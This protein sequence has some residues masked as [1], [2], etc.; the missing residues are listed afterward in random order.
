[1]DLTV[2]DAARSELFAMMLQG[3]VTLGLALVCLVLYLRYRKRYFAYWTLAWSLYAL[4][5][6]AIISFVLTSDR[7]W[8]YWHQ[9]VTGMTALALLWTALV[10]SR[11]LPW[12][13][14][15]LWLALFPVV[16]SYLAIY[17]LDNFLLAALPAVA[18]LSIATLWTGWVF[19][20]YHRQVESTGAASLALTL[21]LWGLHHLD[22]PFL[23][24]RGAWDPWGYYLD[25]LFILAMG[26]GILLLVVE[27]Q[28]RGI[29][30][31]SALSGD[32]HLAGSRDHVDGLTNLL[33]RPL[34]LAGV[35]GSAMYLLPDDELERGGRF[36]GGVGVCAEWPK[37]Q[38]GGVAARAIARAV[39]TREPQIEHGAGKANGGSTADMAH[40]SALPVIRGE[41]VW[42][43]LVMV[44]DLSDPFAV[45]D[46]RF[47]VTLGQ[48]VGAALESAELNRRLEARTGDLERLAARMV[49]QHEE[50]RKRLARELHDE[51]AQVFSAI[52]LHL[53][54][55]RE[56]ASQEQQNRLDRVM[57]LVDEGI[58]SVR[59]VARDLRPELL[60]DLGLVPALRAVVTD[61]EEQSGL[62]TQLNIRHTLPNLSDEA[63]LAL[64]RAL[65]EGLSNVARHADAKSVEVTLEAGD[66]RIRMVVCDDGSG[67]NGEDLDGLELDGHMGL[68]GMRERIS[69]LGGAVALRSNSTTGLSLQVELPLFEESTGE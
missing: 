50:E 40:V 31:L 64:F 29:G 53:D 10:F 25:I 44:G 61:F 2:T 38:P 15:Y 62:I 13:N 12:R 56:S 33:Q 1:M 23:R 4:R 36:I 24:A 27:E 58:R 39:E 51:T 45:L 41:E 30:M 63:E 67:W 14:R 28:H 34:K 46:N 54:V 48:Q 19:F 66:D 20:R 68:V 22:Y 32:L 8:L 17:R 9:V 60:D 26:T 11:Q 42:G 47:L 35:R 59:N 37:I 57:S 7:V 6:G 49:K 18:F 16:W 43:V 21:F 52:K 65:Q 69:A 5:L 3:V 55:L